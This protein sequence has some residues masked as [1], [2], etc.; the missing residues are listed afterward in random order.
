MKRFKK[1]IASF[2]TF[3]ALFTITPVVAH[4]EWKSDNRGWWNTKG[5]SYSIGWDK[6][7]GKWY[8]F[9][10]DGYMKTGWIKYDAVWYYLSNSGALDNS[11]TTKTMPAQS[12]TYVQCEE[13]A[14]AWFSNS[15]QRG[16]KFKV[17]SDKKL[18]D[19]GKYFF[20][21][22]SMDLGKDVGFFGVSAITG[23]VIE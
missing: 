5:N 20:T 15:H 17:I 14:S 6:I 13:I 7:D 12:Y 21:I 11:M 10:Y 9:K 18:Y 19:D 22:Y 8:Y 2:V 1:I 4:A 23:E 16:Y 3:L